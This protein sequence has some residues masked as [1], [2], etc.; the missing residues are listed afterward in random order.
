MVGSVGANEFEVENAKDGDDVFLTVD[1][2]IQKEIESIAQH[3]LSEFSADS[4]S[5]LVYDPLS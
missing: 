2:G 3:Y 5:I 4:I 1:V